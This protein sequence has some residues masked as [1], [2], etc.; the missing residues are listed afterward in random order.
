[1]RLHADRP[2]VIEVRDMASGATTRVVEDAMMWSYYPDWS[3]DDWFLAFSTSPAHH[4]GEDWDLAVYRFATKGVTRLTRGR[5]TTG[6]RLEAVSG[7][8]ACPPIDN[9]T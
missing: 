5:G 8:A 2:S 3:P 6:A 1:M 9:R 7:T 4:E